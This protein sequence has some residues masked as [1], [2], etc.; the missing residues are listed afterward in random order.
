MIIT[1]RNKVEFVLP[2]VLESCT[3]LKISDRLLAT[4]T[5]FNIQKI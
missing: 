5:Q 2:K 1:A 4:H 3:K